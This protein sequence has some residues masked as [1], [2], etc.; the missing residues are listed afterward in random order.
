MRLFKILLR[1]LV[2][3]AIFGAKAAER[4]VTPSWWY[5]TGAGWNSYAAP[6]VN[7]WFSYGTLVSK[8][9]ELYVITSW[10]ATSAKEQSY[11]VQTSV[12]TGL[13]TIVKRMGPVTVVG[14]GEMGAAASGSNL[15][16][17]FGT[18]GLGVMRLG[19]TDWTLV[20]GAR[21]IKTAL[22]NQQTI[23]E[24]GIGRLGVSR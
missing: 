13:A 21:V 19:K 17:A 3:C 22:S 15:G 2:S 12:R 1:V 8:K 4:A 9:R 18:G 7:A 16:V 23:F 24:F 20:F 6:E 11:A 5:G 14:L 10:D